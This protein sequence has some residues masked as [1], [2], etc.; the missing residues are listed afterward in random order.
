MHYFFAYVSFDQKIVISLRITS[1]L[2]ASLK[3]FENVIT[4]LVNFVCNEKSFAIVLLVFFFSLD[5]LPKVLLMN[6][7]PGSVRPRSDLFH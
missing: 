4:I 6:C 7:Y 2:P 3:I 1:K 5:K